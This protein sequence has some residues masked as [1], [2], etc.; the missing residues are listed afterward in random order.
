VFQMKQRPRIHYPEAQNSLMW[1]SWQ[2]GGSLS[3]TAL[4]FTQ[5]AFSAAWIHRKDALLLHRRD[6][7]SIPVICGVRLQQLSEKIG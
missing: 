4:G 7:D 3:S 2:K 1:D 5:S 6:A